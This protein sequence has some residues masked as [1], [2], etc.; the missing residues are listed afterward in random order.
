MKFIERNDCVRNNT[1]NYNE[2]LFYLYK[3]FKSLI[4]YNGMYMN[5][6]ISF[7]V[8]NNEY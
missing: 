3:I 8:Y 6:Y 2:Y 4:L 1:C 5:G 7:F